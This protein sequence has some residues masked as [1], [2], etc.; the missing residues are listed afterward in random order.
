MYKNNINYEQNPPHL[1]R[2]A[3]KYENVLRENALRLK[4]THC[5]ALVQRGKRLSSVRVT[6]S[7]II[8]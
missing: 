3:L 2:S 7:S 4:R 6:R 8:D 5:S 1:A